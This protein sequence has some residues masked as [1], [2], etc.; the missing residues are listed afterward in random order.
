MFRFFTV[1]GTWGRPDLALY[2]F[3]S[4]ILYLQLWQVAQ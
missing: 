1:Y 3:V 2:K 4:A